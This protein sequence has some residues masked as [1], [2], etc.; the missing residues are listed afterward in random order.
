MKKELTVPRILVEGAGQCADLMYASGFHPVDPVVFLDEGKHRTLVVPM[1]EYGRA[2]IECPGVTVLLPDDIA[3]PKDRR[4]SLSAWAVALLAHRAITHVQ[5]AAF[6]PAGIARELEKNGVTVDICS[7]AMYPRRAQKTAAEID[8]ITVA[9]RAAVAAMR[10]AE[11]QLAEATIGRA[12]VLR[13]N[14]KVLT[15]EIVRETIDLTLLRHGCIARDTIVAGGALAADPHDRGLGPLKAGTT[16]VIDIFPQHKQSQYWG[17]ITRTF[18][19]G[20]PSPALAR[21]YQTVMVAQQ[22]ALAMIRPGV[23]G[24]NVHAMITA[25]FEQQGYPTTVKDGVVR[26]FFHGTGHGVGLDIHEA[27]SI[28]TV[29]VKLKAGNVVT[30]EPGLYDPDVGGVRIEDTVVIEPGGARILCRYPK[31]FEV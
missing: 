9:Q 7:G 21:L 17:D 4:R 1:L 15:A 2:K 10:A 28:S 16:I 26:G 6:F 25:Y 31:R 24:P 3:V 12:G 30:V 19:K 8:H 22:R 13:W 11:H 18:C 5:V 14:K 20:P 23:A 29:P 27:P